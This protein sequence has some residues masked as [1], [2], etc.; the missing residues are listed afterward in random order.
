MMM[1]S[2]RLAGAGPGADRYPRTRASGPNP[3]RRA[4]QGGP[5][6][7]ER[8]PG[9]VRV[10]PERLLARRTTA[11]LAHHHHPPTILSCPTVEA[12]AGPRRPRARRRVPGGAALRG[13]GGRGRGDRARGGGG[14]LSAPRDSA[15]IG[16]RLRR[17]GLAWPG[18]PRLGAAD[19]LLEARRC[20][21]RDGMTHVV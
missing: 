6:V 1:R 19:G 4:R 9:A 20:D 10:P 5:G 7:G 21:A 12:H 13:E 15:A 16:A 18:R 11:Q 2:P 17:P 8:V 3:S 14:R